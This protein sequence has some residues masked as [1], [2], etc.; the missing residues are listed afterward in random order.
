MLIFTF[1]RLRYSRSFFFDSTK[2]KDWHNHASTHL[3][4]LP[5]AHPPHARQRKPQHLSAIHPA[6]GRLREDEGSRSIQRTAQIEICRSDRRHA[7]GPRM[8]KRMVPRRRRRS[9]RVRRQD[10]V[11]PHPHGRRMLRIRQKRLPH[12]W[13]DRPQPFRQ[14]LLQRPFRSR[15]TEARNEN[16][17]LDRSSRQRSLRHQPAR[18]D[19]YQSA[20][21][22]GLIRRLH[23]RNV[24]LRVR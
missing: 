3:R 16:R 19:G 23:P 8:G 1:R 10:V 5:R 6:E 11:P 4:H 15:Q 9:E 13:S 7:V 2:I 18:A 22:H 17:L 14:R 24:A 21:A 12:L 20:E